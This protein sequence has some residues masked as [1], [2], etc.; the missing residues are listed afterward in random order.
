MEEQTAIRIL[1]TI[2]QT[3][4]RPAASEPIPEQSAAGALSEAF[5][6]ASRTTPSEG[7]LAEAALD[8]LSH[9]PNFA[10][11]IRLMTAQANSAPNA[12]RY[13]ESSL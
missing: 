9:D 3:R 2:A 1:K 12:Q 5:G 6:T 7:E 11:P 10:E 4:L 13:V 8:L